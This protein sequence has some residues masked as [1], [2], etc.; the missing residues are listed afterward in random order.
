MLSA[1]DKHLSPGV[2]INTISLPS[3]HFHKRNKLPWALKPLWGS[4]DT[5]C[6]YSYEACE[7]Q[8]GMGP[9]CQGEASHHPPELVCASVMLFQWEPIKEQN[10]CDRMR[11]GVPGRMYRALETGIAQVQ[12]PC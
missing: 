5:E 3:L 11:R 9:P 12:N 10:D 8:E 7:L 2:L 1:Q 6:S 4:R